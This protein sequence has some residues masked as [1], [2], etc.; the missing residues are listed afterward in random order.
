M[1]GGGNV[2]ID[3]A[4]TAQRCGAESVSMFCLEPRDKM[5]ASEEEIAEALED[6]YDID[7]K[8]VKEGYKVDVEM[9]IKGSEDDKEEEGTLNII[10]ISSNKFFFC[11]FTNLLENAV[12]H[13]KSQK[14]IDFY[15]EKKC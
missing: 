2:A 9:L 7:T 5:P 8:S 13:G 4:R 11:T 10:K 3:V 12:V 14:P 15:I 1:V 6:T